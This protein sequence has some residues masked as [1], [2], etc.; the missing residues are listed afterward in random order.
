MKLFHDVVRKMN[1]SENHPLSSKG[2]QLQRVGA[3]R[4]GKIGVSILYFVLYTIKNSRLA[5]ALLYVHA[6]PWQSLGCLPGC[7]GVGVSRT[8]V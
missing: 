8:R 3:E 7:P 4:E 1:F 2:A 5:T 6:D